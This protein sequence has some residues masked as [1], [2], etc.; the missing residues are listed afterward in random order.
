[1]EKMIRR[2]NRKIKI[3]RTGFNKF[4]I[5]PIGLPLNVDGVV[6]LKIGE[7]IQIDLPTL[8][9]PESYK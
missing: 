1:M 3:I 5:E 2:S 7:S 9:I 6:D 8:Y 4:A